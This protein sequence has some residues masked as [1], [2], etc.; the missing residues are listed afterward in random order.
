MESIYK[1]TSDLQHVNIDGIIKLFKDI[2]KEQLVRP[3]GTVDVRIGY[4]YAGYHPSREQSVGHLVL[5]RNSF[6]RCIGGMHPSGQAPKEKH[7]LLNAQAHSVRV[8]RVE[9]FYNI[10]HVGIQFLPKCGGC[11]C[12]K[13]APGSKNYTLKEEKEL[14]PIEQNLEFDAKTQ[15][16]IT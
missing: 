4:E 3:N 2:P 5:L 9:D 7:P 1:I 12:G 14:E 11:K 10:E 8:V 6:G 16:W 15:S 13:C